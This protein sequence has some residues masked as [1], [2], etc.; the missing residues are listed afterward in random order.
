MSSLVPRKE[1]RTLL[2]WTFVAITIVM[3]ASVFGS[4]ALALYLAF[5]VGPSTKP[6]HAAYDLVEWWLAWASL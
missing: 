3:F 1:E 2:W 5:I 4:L 6:D